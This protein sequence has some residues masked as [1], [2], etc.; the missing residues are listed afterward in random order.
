MQINEIQNEWGKATSPAQLPYRILPICGS[1]RP[2]RA[3]EPLPNNL[4]GNIFRFFIVNFYFKQTIS[5][6]WAQ[7]SIYSILNIFIIFFLF[8]LQSKFGLE[9]RKLWRFCLI[10]SFCSLPSPLPLCIN[11]RL[12]L[13]S[14]SIV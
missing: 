13:V 12:W 8:F 1:A 4:P 9:K 10:S 2:N 7:Y 11:L 6:I 14:F 3:S 5:N